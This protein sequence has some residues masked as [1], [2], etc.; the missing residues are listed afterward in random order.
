MAVPVLGLVEW[1]ERKPSLES[2]QVAPL[3]NL[4]V[5]TDKDMFV[6]YSDPHQDRGRG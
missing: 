4:C 6:L 1:P 2:H 5:F 3:V